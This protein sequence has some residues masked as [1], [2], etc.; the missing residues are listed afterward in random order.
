VLVLGTTLDQPIAHLHA[1]QAMQHVL[2]LATARGLAGS[3]VAPPLEVAATRAELRRLLG[4]ALWPQ[5]LLRLGVRERAV[6]R[7]PRRVPGRAERAPR[8]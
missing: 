3:F 1:G 6:P 4:G 8:P 5:V 2:L 7:P